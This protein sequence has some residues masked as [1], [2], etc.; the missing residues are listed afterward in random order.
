MIHERYCLWVT[1]HWNRVT[2]CYWT[3]RVF[4]G[5]STN[6]WCKIT[7]SYLNGG[8]ASLET[9]SFMIYITCKIYSDCRRKIR[10]Y[11][12]YWTMDYMRSLQAGKRMEKIWCTC[13]KDRNQSF[14][15]T[16]FIRVPYS[17]YSWYPGIPLIGCKA[18]LIWNYR[19]SSCSGLYD[20]NDNYW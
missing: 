18:Y 7:K 9:S 5:F 19:M 11:Y 10:D 3:K 4:Y 17:R 16:I 20:C 15:K 2:S 8:I 6:Y 13:T 12:C 14:S 1:I